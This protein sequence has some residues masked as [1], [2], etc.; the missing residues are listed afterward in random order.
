MASVAVE[1]T[2]KEIHEACEY[3]ATHRVLNEGKALSSE[4]RAT[5][6]ST[7]GSGFIAGCTVWVQTLRM[8]DI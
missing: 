8:E 6:D 5:T 4:L 3:W 1:L 2:E 7:K